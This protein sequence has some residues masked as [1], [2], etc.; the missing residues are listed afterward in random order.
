MKGGGGFAHI[1][2]G[3]AEEVVSTHTL[4]GGA[5]AVEPL[6]GDFQCGVGSKGNIVTVKT[7]CFV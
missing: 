7:V 5:V 1:T 4:V 2:I 6:C 3:T